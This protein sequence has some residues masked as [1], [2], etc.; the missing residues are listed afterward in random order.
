MGEGKGD[1]Q[2]VAEETEGEDRQGEGV[3]G[4]LGVAIEEA[5]EGFIVVF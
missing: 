3:A 2:E 4:A 5:G 1:G